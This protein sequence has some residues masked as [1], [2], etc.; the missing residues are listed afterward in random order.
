MGNSKKFI[1]RSVSVQTP[2]QASQR[3]Q[4]GPKRAIRRSFSIKVRDDITAAA[5]VLL[6]T[7]FI[8]FL[9]LPANCLFA[10][11]SEVLKRK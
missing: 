7:S 6:L 2:V 8:V 9:I 11:L 5:K 10:K 1:A 4:E 3:G